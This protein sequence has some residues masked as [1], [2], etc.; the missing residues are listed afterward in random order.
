MA[1]GI[2]QVFPQEVLQFTLVV[3]VRPYRIF[4]LALLLLHIKGYPPLRMGSPYLPPP[5]QG[6]LHLVHHMDQEVEVGIETFIWE[7]G[8]QVLLAHIQLAHLRVGPFQV[9]F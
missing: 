6:L 3:L 2:I 1:H 5:H 8:S 4:T 9:L 7:M